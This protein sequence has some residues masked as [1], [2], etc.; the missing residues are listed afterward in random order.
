M[1]NYRLRIRDL[2]YSLLPDGLA[3]AQA[4]DFGSGDGW[5]AASLEQDRKIAQV[6]AVDVQRRKNS[7][8]EPLLYDGG[9]LPFADQSFDVVYAVD[10]LHHCKDPEGQLKD[11]LRCCRQHFLLKD[12]T[13]RSPFGWLTLCLLDEVGNRKFGIPSRYKYQY[14]WSWFDLIEREGFILKRLIHPAHVESRF[15]GV[16]T[17]QLQFI[18]LWCRR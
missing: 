9:T 17:N 14:G 10:V 16:K 5:F 13:Y 12:H 6:T 3:Q 4:L 8:K 15:W 11:L 7:F 1:N 18:A 2:I